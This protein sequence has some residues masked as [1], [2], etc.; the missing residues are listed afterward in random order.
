MPTQGFAVQPG[1][2]YTIRIGVADAGDANVD[3]ALFL[4]AGSLAL[5]A[6]PTVSAGGPYTAVRRGGVG[7]RR[8]PR[9]A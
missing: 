4:R 3:T 5:T 2:V 9:L 6:P 1:T 7:P 8:R